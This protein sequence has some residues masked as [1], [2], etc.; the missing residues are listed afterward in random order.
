MEDL[1]ANENTI[2]RFPKIDNQDKP[3]V[4]FGMLDHC[5]F[6]CTDAQQRSP[7][8]PDRSLLQIMWHQPFNEAC[9]K[10]Y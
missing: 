1:A 10:I 5:T 6:S 9:A 3:N 4:V 8:V 7:L 2:K